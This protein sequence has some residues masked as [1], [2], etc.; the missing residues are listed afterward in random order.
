[1]ALAGVAQAAAL[2]DKLACTGYDEAEPFNTLVYSLLETNPSST[3]SVYKDRLHLRLGLETLRRIMKQD[4]VDNNDQQNNSY[5][6]NYGEVLRYTLSMIHLERKLSNNKAMLD[7]IGTRIEQIKRQ[8]EHFNTP[9][10]TSAYR[11]ESVLA[12]IAST[13]A[14]TIST[15][16]F[17]IQV[18]GNPDYLKQELIVHKIRCLLLCGIRS[19]VLWKQMGGGRFNILLNRKKHAEMAIELLKLH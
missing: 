6:Y 10:G 12:N 1:M 5:S 15:F 14:D 11:N 13:Y 18:N 17:R 9:D 4:S 8:V 19:A 7:N 16:R 3:E 2:V